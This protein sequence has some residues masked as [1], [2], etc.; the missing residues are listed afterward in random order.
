MIDADPPVGELL[1]ACR[2]ESVTIN[3]GSL[4]AAPTG[5]KAESLEAIS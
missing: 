1:V 2:S 4:L 5:F 3:S